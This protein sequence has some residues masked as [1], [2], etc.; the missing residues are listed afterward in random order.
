MHFEMLPSKGL[1]DAD[2]SPFVLI[3][4]TEEA[5]IV[6][7]KVSEVSSGVRR[8]AAGE[9]RRPMARADVETLRGIEWFECDER[10]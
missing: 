6:G 7:H 5:S 8:S 9:E 10:K 4:D 3:Q 1:G 2:P